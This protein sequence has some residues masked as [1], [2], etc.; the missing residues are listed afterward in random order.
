MNDNEQVSVERLCNV[1]KL[2]HS[3]EH[4]RK[5][6]YWLSMKKLLQSASSTLV[7]DA[8]LFIAHAPSESKNTF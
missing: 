6:N 4:N 8:S 3:S 7:P 2:S 5:I 1:H